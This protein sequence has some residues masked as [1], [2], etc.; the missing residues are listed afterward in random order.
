MSF[1]ALT[2]DV[3]AKLAGLETGL[4]RVEDMVGKT[5]GSIAGLSSTVGVLKTGL[6]GLG[7]GLSAGLFAKA[8]I[9]AADTFA[10]VDTQ[11]K[12]ATATT[13]EFAEAQRR[14][15]DIA[16]STRQSYAN[17]ATTY[18]QISAS[19]GSSIGTQDQQLRFFE[20]VSKA[21]TLS[22]AS[23]EQANAA[24]L[25]FRQGLAAG[26]LRGEELN[27]V[28]EQTPRLARAI[29]EGLGVSI[30]QLREMGKAGELTAEKIVGA[31]SNAAGTID[32]E[33][34][35]VVPTF[36]SAMTKMGNSVG[37]LFKRIEDGTGGPVLELVNLLNW[38]ADKL[39]KLTRSESV[40]ERVGRLQSNMQ[41]AETGTG[42]FAG[43]DQDSRNAYLAQARQQMEALREQSRRMFRESENQSSQA[44]AS[45]DAARAESAAKAWEKLA[46]QY[47]STAEKAA[48]TAAEIRKAG[49]AAGKSEVEIQRLIN[50]AMP[51]GNGKDP[52]ADWIKEAE[53]ADKARMEMLRERES[54]EEFL[55]KVLFDDAERQR[56][57]INDETDANRRRA[58]A[59]RDLLDPTRKYTQQLEEIKRLTAVGVNAGG[60]SQQQGDL[61]RFLVGNELDGLYAGLDKFKERLD[62]AD[63]WAKQAANNIQDALGDGLYDILSGNFDSI[64]KSF[65]NMLKRMLA[66][67]TAAQISR[68]LFGDFGTKSGSVGGLLGEGLKWL[69]GALGFKVPSH[70]DGLDYVPYDGY[71]A[72]LH[73][74]E[75]VQTA[76]EARSRSPSVVIH[77]TVT[78]APGM[79]VAQFE[80]MLDER[81]ARLVANIGQGLRRGRFDWAMA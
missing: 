18:A 67:A 17:L 4:K 29:A 39:D 46:N 20:T 32:R 41:Q 66:E 72:K 57:A 28:M 49:E 25:Q 74:G 6:A 22:G 69:G 7:A 59:W 35:A 56:K 65:S 80:A 27:S 64:G 77:S 43:M 33:F 52:L 51:K 61:A 53:K 79:D 9:N 55:G 3:N 60:L 47:A 31:M 26:A 81:D 2:I 58:D 14:L 10:R 24:L 62:E 63:Q 78:A 45:M 75:R 44:S 68:A 76:S 19:A 13:L 12:N 30:G 1:A 54:F 42:A 73:R 36:D 38:A 48:K 37:R 70:A 23:A 71:I 15:F 5:S 16:Q 11:L 34:N 8:F 40:S 21:I 50:N